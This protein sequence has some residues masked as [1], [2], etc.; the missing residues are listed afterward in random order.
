M[1][2]I[3]NPCSAR[4]PRG[5]KNSTSFNTTNL[6]SRGDRNIKSVRGGPP[7]VPIIPITGDPVVIRIVYLL[8]CLELNE[9]I[10]LSC[11]SQ[12]LA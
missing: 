2:A 7:T 3:C 5:E 4:V 11:L 8:S 6:V 12:Q 10:P 1:I 9:M